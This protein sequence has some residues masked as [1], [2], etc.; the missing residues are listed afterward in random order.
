MTTVSSRALAEARSA[1]EQMQK[2]AKQPSG[3]LADA[4]SVLDK[5]V[6]AV[7]GAG[8]GP[9]GAAAA[10]PTISSI[11]AEIGALYG[12]VDR[13]DATPTVSQVNAG[14][15]NEESLSQVMKQCDALK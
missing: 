2:L 4:I 12:E 5:K 15:E 1:R 13:A 6:A 8:G 3:P 11:S 9:R 14:T 7:L 10:A